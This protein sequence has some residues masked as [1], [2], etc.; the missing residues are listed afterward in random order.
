MFI[1][2]IW[3]NS[4]IC[5]NISYQLIV[6][7]KFRLVRFGSKFNEK[8]VSDQMYVCVYLIDKELLDDKLHMLSHQLVHKD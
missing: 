8:R 3:I 4:F 2:S 6:K 5:D 1:I 7:F